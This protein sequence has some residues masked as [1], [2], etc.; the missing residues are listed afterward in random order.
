MIP[1]NSPI[2][3]SAFHL[4]KHYISLNSYLNSFKVVSGLALASPP[5]WLPNKNSSVS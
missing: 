3:K 5:M 4:E 1:V 2:A